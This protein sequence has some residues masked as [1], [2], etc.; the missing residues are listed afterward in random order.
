MHPRPAR[1]LCI[2]KEL[3]VLHTRCAVLRRAGYDTR[4]ATLAEAEA[5]LRRQEVD[6]VI[7]SAWLSE[8]EKGRILSTA[9]NTPTLVLDGFTLARDLLAK[10]EKLLS[11]AGEQKR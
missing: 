8:W 5:L 3:E 6:A 10:V 7:V 11:P 9:V 4:A 2:G 1:L